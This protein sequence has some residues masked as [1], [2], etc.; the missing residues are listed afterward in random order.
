MTRHFFSAAALPPIMAPVR[1]AHDMANGHPGAQREAAAHIGNRVLRIVIDGEAAPGVDATSGKVPDGNRV[2]V[3][4]VCIPGLLVYGSRLQRRARLALGRL[5]RAVVMQIAQCTEKEE[6]E[7]CAA[8]R[9][10][11]GTAVANPG[12]ARARSPARGV[13]RRARD[14]RVATRRR[15]GRTSHG[16]EQRWHLQCDRP[17]FAE[18]EVQERAKTGL[19]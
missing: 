14:F 5:S 16:T 9:T 12:A 1:F 17:I 8:P 11:D 10:L 4:P 18:G 2:I 19:G 7:F 13:G 15:P 3:R 6:G